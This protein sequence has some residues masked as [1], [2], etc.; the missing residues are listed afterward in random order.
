MPYIAVQAQ[1]HTPS[2]TQP[3]LCLKVPECEVPGLWKE[4][5]KGYKVDSGNCPD[6]KGKMIWITATAEDCRR[7]MT[8]YLST[9]EN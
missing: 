1:K 5:F 8:P 3:R 4:A 2:D 7:D 9:C 6:M